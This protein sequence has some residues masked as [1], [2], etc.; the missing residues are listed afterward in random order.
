MRSFRVAA[1]GSLMLCAGVLFACGEDALFGDSN[2]PGGGSS[3]DPS[4]PIDSVADE[5]GAGE[6]ASTTRWVFLTKNDDNGSEVSVVRLSNGSVDG[7]F[8]SEAKQSATSISPLGAFF[9]AS[10]REVVLRLND[11]SPWTSRASWGFGDVGSPDASYVPSRPVAVIPTSATKAYVALYERNHLAVLD[12]ADAGSQ[13]PAHTIDLG[14]YVSPS[15]SDGLVETIG[16]YYSAP[17]KRL[18]VVL[19][20]VDR[21]QNALSGGYAC[22]GTRAKVVA[23]D[24]S[25]DLP[26]A[27][28]D[29][30]TGYA[31]LAGYAQLSSDSIAYDPSGDRLLI[32]SRGCVDNG[33]IARRQIESVSLASG[34]VTTLA[35]INDQPAPRAIYRIDSNRVVIAF[36]E[37]AKMW[38]PNSATLGALIVGAPEA[39]AF[40]GERS[41][42]GIR[43]TKSDGGIVARELIA[44][45]LPVEDAGG[46]AGDA[47]TEAGS[48]VLQSAPF[49]SLAGTV[50]RVEISEK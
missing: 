44:T 21:T 41:L 3:P 33:V 12:L 45:P 42:I 38:N 35:T 8:L 31:E 18:Y 23:F 30:G 43:T 39:F 50:S 2:L 48:S 40:D 26:V 34:A 36:D 4:Q 1:L 17:R 19:G 7:R 20:S 16:G 32:A 27:L 49:G 28:G 22:T 29:G 24:V 11:D 46:D 13:L 15:D 6:D 9:V 25:T 10:D 47:T 14:P 5:G 37:S